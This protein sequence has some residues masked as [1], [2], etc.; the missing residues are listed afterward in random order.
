MADV[1]LYDQTGFSGTAVTVNDRTGPEGQWVFY[2]LS[3]LGLSQINSITVPAL[4]HVPN[5]GGPAGT[6]HTNVFLYS[7]RPTNSNYN[8][9]SGEGTV[10]HRFGSSVADTGSAN[11][12]QYIAVSSSVAIGNLSISVPTPFEAPQ[13][14][15]AGLEFVE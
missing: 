1:V 15:N 13:D 14:P 4:E 12:P 10:F 3:S 6:R 9:Q 5:S 7:G 2:S 11:T 8:M